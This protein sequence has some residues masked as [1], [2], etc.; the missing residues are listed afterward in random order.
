MTTINGYADDVHGWNFIGGKDGR[1]VN[2]NSQ[3]EARVYY[4]FKSKFDSTNLDTANL[5]PGDKEEYKVVDKAK[6][7]VMGD[8]SDNNIDLGTLHHVLQ[9]CVKS[10]SILQQ[11]MGKPEYTGNDLDTFQVQTPDSRSAKSV[12]LYLFKA[13]KI[14]DMSNKQF[15]SEFTEEVQSEEKKEATKENAPEDVRHEIVGDNEADFKDRYYGNSDVMAGDPM[16]G[17]HVWGSSQPSGIMAR[18]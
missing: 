12:I 7:T 16:H 18:G 5:S 9:A 3:E 17:T 14:M 11:A 15:L 1:S 8:G 2:D 13:N 4:M 6:K 10:D